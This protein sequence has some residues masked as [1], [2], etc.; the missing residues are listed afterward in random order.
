[1]YT[2][3]SS[4]DRKNIAFPIGSSHGLRPVVRG[5]NLWD[6]AAHVRRD[7]KPVFSDAASVV[8]PG[9]GFAGSSSD[10]GIVR[11]SRVLRLWLFEPVHP[12]TASRTTPRSEESASWFSTL[13][14]WFLYFN[15]SADFYG[16]PSSWRIQRG[17]RSPERPHL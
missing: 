11:V 12:G 14:L 17:F 9:T 4:C 13:S 3:T 6:S 5:H 1:M 15:W 10:R 2:Y 8:P 7:A 16:L